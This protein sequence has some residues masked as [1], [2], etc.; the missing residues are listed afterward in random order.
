MQPSIPA[1]AIFQLRVRTGTSTTDLVNDNN[2]ISLANG[3]MVET[4]GTGA[5]SLT[6]TA[7][8]GTDANDGIQIISDSRVTSVNGSIN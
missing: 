6:G 4:S 5:I 3:S 7:G 1:L 8:A 2:G